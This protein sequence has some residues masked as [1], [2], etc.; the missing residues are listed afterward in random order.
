MSDN[1]TRFITEI[2]ADCAQHGVTLNLVPAKKIKI[3]IGE[4]SGLW[5]EE[6]KQISVAV[7]TDDWIK[8]LAHEY[9]HFCQYKEGKFASDEENAAFNDIDEWLDNKLDLTPEQINDKIKLI[10]DCELDC[11][12]RAVEFIKKYEIDSEKNI[13]KYIQR[14]NAYVLSY[15][16]LKTKRKWFEYSAHGI[17]KIVNKMPK[18]FIEDFTVSSELNNLFLEKCYD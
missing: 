10:Q 7:L 4:L 18:V 9:G 15:E 13:P 5:D 2:I 3:E 14:A 1:I 12:K 17:T 6:T 11:E 8:V 16:V